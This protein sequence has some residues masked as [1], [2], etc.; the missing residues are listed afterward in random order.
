MKRFIKLLLI[1]FISFICMGKVNAATAKFN[2]TSSSSQVIVGN[3]VTVYVTI[4]SSLGLGSWEYTLN[5]NSSLFKFKSSDVGLHYAAVANNSNTKSV[6]YK[7]VFTSLKAGSAKFYVDSTSAIS[8]VNEDVMSVSN[9]SK[10]ITAISYADYQASLSSN[11]YLKS[12]SV[13]G[14]SLNPVFD[15]DTEEYIVQV[16]EDTKSI[17]INA[18]VADSTAKVSGTGTFDVDA[19]NNAFEVVVVAQNGS[20]RTYKI[21]VE[22]L[23]KN[24]INVEL[25]GENYTVVK[26]SSNLKKP[27]SY[28]EKEINIKGFNIPAF[29]SDV[30]K[31]TLVGLKD[32]KGNIALYKYDNDKYEKYT[33]L[34]FGNLTIYP[35]EERK[36]VEHF[37]ESS[38]KIQGNEIKSLKSTLNDRYYLVYGLN[39]ETSEE[40]YYLYDEKDQSLILF[41]EKSFNELLHQN[42]I[43]MLVILVFGVSTFGFFIIILCMLHKNKKLKNMLKEKK[44]ESRKKSEKVEEKPKKVEKDEK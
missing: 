7:Y 30:T 41:D 26:I 6:T 17:K 16:N 35:L 19:G 12:L 34:I 2:V 22:V 25:D 27:A 40:G 4:S 39:V 31:F 10:T 38:I 13:E 28:E 21:T 14:Q 24:P 37:T 32:S 33:E 23:D 20:E 11:N 42:K 36:S 43:L 44:K 9:G 8:F 5:Y 15:K 3:S 18:Q 1:V 29:Y